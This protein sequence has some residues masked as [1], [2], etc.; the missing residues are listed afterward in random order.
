RRI[1]LQP[2]IRGGPEQPEACSVPPANFLRRSI[3]I[4]GFDDLNETLVDLRGASEGSPRRLDEL[5]GSPS[6]SEG[7]ELFRLRLGLDAQTGRPQDEAV[8]LG[9]R[10]RL[11]RNGPA[12]GSQLPALQ[13]HV[14]ES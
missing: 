11:V 9:G 10:R 4:D 13:A 2:E 1:Q 14:R 5:G 6:F 12:R 8:E 3:C 7:L